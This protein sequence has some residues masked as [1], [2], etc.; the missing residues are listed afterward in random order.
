MT[1]YEPAENVVKSIMRDAI[2][3]EKTEARMCSVIRT[4]LRFEVRRILKC[5]RDKAEELVP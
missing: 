5:E 3:M 4:Y 2:E 1:E